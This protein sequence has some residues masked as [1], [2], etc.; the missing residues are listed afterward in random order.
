MREGEFRGEFAPKAKHQTSPTNVVIVMVEEHIRS[1]LLRCV[2]CQS[3]R[4]TDYI[5]VSLVLAGDS[6]IREVA[7]RLMASARPA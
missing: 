7:V 1:R 6:R 3:S 2:S 5:A 4:Y